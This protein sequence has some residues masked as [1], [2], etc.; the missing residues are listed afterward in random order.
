MTDLLSE[1]ASTEPNPTDLAHLYPDFDQLTPGQQRIL[2]AALE[3][4]AEKGYAATSTGSIARQ[5]GVAEGLIFKHFRNKKELLLKLARPLILGVFF[6]LS[7]RRIQVIVAQDYPQLKDMLEALLRERLA[8]V[9]QHHRLLRLV[10][11]EI[12]LHPELLETLQEQ[13]KTHLQPTMET[14][15][16][17]FSSLGQ[18]R[19]MPFGTTLRLIMSCFMGLILPRV[20]LFPDLAWQEE[21]EIEQTIQTLVQGL[22]PKPRK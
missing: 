21:I 3:L 6:P 20:L 5:A 18:I 8:F 19:E 12:L 15:L 16:Q 4:F 10:V 7:V 22:A 2:G 11:Q 14:R 9:R 1:A 17:H 13:F